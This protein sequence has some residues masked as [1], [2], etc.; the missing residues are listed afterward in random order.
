MNSTS[1]STTTLHNSDHYSDSAVGNTIRS[2]N[3]LEDYQ[4]RMSS[5]A[6][7]V[8]S[9]DSAEVIGKLLFKKIQPSLNITFSLLHF[10]HL[11]GITYLN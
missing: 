11:T 3:S 5:D 8:G 9:N 10:S 1:V 7:S 4:S 6:I 2:V